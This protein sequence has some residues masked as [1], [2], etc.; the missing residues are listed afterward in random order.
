MPP[1]RRESGRKRCNAGRPNAWGASSSELVGLS[2]ADWMPSGL[3]AERGGRRA[4]SRA[5]RALPGSYAL[6]TAVSTLRSLRSA[7]CAPRSAPPLGSRRATFEPQPQSGEFVG[8]MA[9]Q[10]RAE[11]KSAG[12]LTTDQLV[13]AYRTMLLSRRL[14]DKEIQLK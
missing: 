9:T 7:L 8:S 14:D 13:G 3:R 12:G 6:P 2:N 5:Q 11:R 10:T 4:E 1:R